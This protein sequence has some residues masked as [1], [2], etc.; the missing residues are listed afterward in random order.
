MIDTSGSMN[1][2]LAGN[3]IPEGRNEKKRLE[4]AQEAAFNFL[5]KLSGDNRVKSQFNHI[6]TV[7]GVAQYYRITWIS[8]LDNCFSFCVQGVVQRE[9]KGYR[10]IFTWLNCN[11]AFISLMLGG[12]VFCSL[13]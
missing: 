11:L 4:I 10:N 12:K 2:N 1:Y 9:I 7:L 6:Q 3:S 13:L 8:F 5:D